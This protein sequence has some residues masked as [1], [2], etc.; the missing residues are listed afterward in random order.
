MSSIPRVRRLPSVVQRATIRF[1]AE[2]TSGS[3]LEPRSRSCASCCRMIA[4]AVRISPLS[5]RAPNP[6]HAASGVLARSAG[7]SRG[8]LV[9]RHKDGRYWARTSDPQLVELVPPSRRSTTDGNERAQPS[10]LSR[11]RDRSMAWLRGRFL[12]GLGQEWATGI[13]GER[14]CVRTSATSKRFEV[15]DGV[16]SG[17]NAALAVVTRRA[18]RRAVPSPAARGV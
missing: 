11:R 15:R 10:G 5:E 8:P 17:L 6:T 14:G 1:R 13:V 9:L 12:R 2:T 3:W 16:R 18:G 7:R 4:K